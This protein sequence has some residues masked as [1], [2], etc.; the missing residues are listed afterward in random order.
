MF[1]RNKI[2]FFL[3]YGLLPF[4]LLK[5]LTIYFLGL[6]PGV[7]FGAIHHPE[8]D[9]LHYDL[10]NTLKYWHYS[11]PLINFI[12]G[13]ILKI[14]DGSLFFV[15]LIYFLI[16]LSMT[17]I[18]LLIGYY[19]CVKFNLSKSKKIIL[20]FFI[21]FNPDI[22]F[23]ENYS[24]P[25]Y[26]HT[27]AFLFS[28]LCYYSFNFFEENRLSDYVKIF[29]VLCIMTYTWTLFHPILLIAVY[30]IFYFMFNIK[31][32]KNLIIFLILL[33]I[34][35]FPFLKNKIVFNFF[36][37]GSHLWIQISQTIP[38]HKENC[39]QPIKD[40]I[41]EERRNYKIDH[42]KWGKIHP[43]LK[44][45]PLDYD[46]AFLHLNLNNLAY[47][48]NSNICKEWFLNKIFND[49]LLY[50]EKRLMSFLSSH[51]RFAFEFVVGA[52]DFLKE[53][54][55]YKDNENI[56]LFKQLILITYM[57]IVYLFFFYSILFIKNKVLKNFLITIMTVYFYL[58]LIGHLF[59]GYEQERMMYGGIF[60]HFLFYLLIF[61]NKK[62]YESK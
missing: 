57:L 54:F 48:K 32:K 44:D 39:F 56:K 26:S 53:I 20:L 37:S 51:S 16:N 33:S 50:P 35:L 25:I 27:I 15:N 59:N 14:T 9:L 3:I 11:P 4:L 1:T 8:K 46:K 13:I 42:E 49:P 2:N 36:G 6:G 52:P 5:I 17:F 7:P 47:L 29:V 41:A 12:L 58:V 21:I 61:N 28:M 60:I 23:Y 19:F 43:S 30:F 31:H 34:S 40:I 22:I 18:I 24:R 10:L 55:S 38:E 45:P 62:N